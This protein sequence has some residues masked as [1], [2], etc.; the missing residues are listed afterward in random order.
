MTTDGTTGSAK[1]SGGSGRDSKASFG[2]PFVKHHKQNEELIFKSGNNQADLFLRV[3][4]AIAD[5]VGIEYGKDMRNLVKYGTE[6]TFQ[7]PTRPD[8]K[9]AKVPGR[10]EEYKEEMAI[11][12][13]ESKMYDDFKAKTYIRILDRCCLEWKHRL[14]KDGEFSK[15]EQDTDV[16][17]ILKKLKAIAFKTDGGQYKPL[18]QANVMRKL[19]G[20]RQGT[21]EK[22]NN[23]YK[24]FLA[25]LEVSNE[26]WGGNLVPANT[27]NKDK[28]KAT[29]NARLVSMIFLDGSDPKRFGKLKNNLHNAF[30]SGT[31][32]YPE[33]LEDVLELL[34]DFEDQEKTGSRQPTHDR[35]DGVSFAQHAKH[36]NGCHLCGSKEHKAYQC[37]RK[38]K[39]NSTKTTGVF[40]Q[41]YQRRY[42]SHDEDSSVESFPVLPSKK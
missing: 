16:V 36:R 5:E 18:I 9:E 27:P 31:D 21:N 42:S 14:E 13:K 23:Y 24:R 30:I 39:D 29:A 41:G 22:T 3:R 33:T 38:N 26:H 35:S 28:D 40:Q 11:Y 7:K 6:K 19:F 8:E 32:N 10:L 17:G 25:T 1:P 34:V 2:S 12:R 20:I 37:P 4:D 15:L